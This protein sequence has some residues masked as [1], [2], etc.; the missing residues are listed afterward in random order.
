MKIF[1]QD[2]LEKGTLGT[3]ICEGSE[4]SRV[5]EM[6]KFN[7]N[8]YRVGERCTIAQHYV[9]IPPDIIDINNVKSKVIGKR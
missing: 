1:A 6:N 3:N 8:K 9:T 7:G 4:E 5:G 2:I